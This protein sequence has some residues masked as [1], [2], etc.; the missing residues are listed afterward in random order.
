MRP[1]RRVAVLRLLSIGS[2]IAVFG[3]MLM[4]G[5]TSASG[6]G[7]ACPDWPLCRGEAIPDLGVAAI[8]VEFAHR[9][10][11]LSAGVLILAAL[12]ATLLWFRTDRRLVL[13]A[14]AAFVLLAAQVALG[15]LTI[16]S[17]LD[18]VVVT[19]HLG[20]ASATFAATVS[21]AWASRLV[22]PAVRRGE[23]AAG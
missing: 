14:A 19:S 4:G 17:A 23:P 7:L 9:L 6:S 11:A 10:L 15:M 16:T 18:P 5:Y 8:A 21:L 1:V 3:T 13:I 12:L 22:T 2:A 20:I